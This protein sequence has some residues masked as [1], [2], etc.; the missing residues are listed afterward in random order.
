MAKMIG[1]IQKL[2]HG[3][4]IAVQGSEEQVFFMIDEFKMAYQKIPLY[5]DG[6]LKVAAQARGLAT[7]WCGPPGRLLDISSL[8]LNHVCNRGNRSH[9]FA[10]IR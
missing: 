10:H 1:I 5:L 6:G 3:W 9:T 4:C 2:G 8:A 7:Y